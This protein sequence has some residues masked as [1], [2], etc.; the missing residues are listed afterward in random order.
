M[1]PIEG[2]RIK[3]SAAGQE[4]LRPRGHFTSR[5]LHQPLPA[6][7]ADFRFSHRRARDVAAVPNGRRTLLL[8]PDL[9]GF[10]VSGYGLKPDRARLGL[11]DAVLLEVA[12]S[13]CNHFSSRKI[14]AMHLSCSEQNDSSALRVR[15]PQRVPHGLVGLIESLARL[16]ECGAEHGPGV[17]SRLVELLQTRFGFGSIGLHFLK[18]GLEIGA[19]GR[20]HFARRRT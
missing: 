19:S 18:R 2:K 6:E 8:Y 5:R 13:S 16:C 14:V 4:R 10:K 1:E 7:T 15:A 3:C 9:L 12:S 11:C 20:S 17:A